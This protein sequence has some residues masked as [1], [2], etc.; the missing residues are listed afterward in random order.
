MP[1]ANDY[2][3]LF[4]AS[5][6]TGCRACQVA[7]KQWN[8]LPGEATENHGSYENP[9]ALS[10]DTWLRMKFTEGVV[11]GEVF[12]DFTRDSC[13]HCTSAACVES[14]PTGAVNYREGG[15]VTI[16]DN[17]CIGCR[18]CVQACPYEAIHFNEQKGVVEKCSMCYDRVSN[19]LEPACVK[20]CPTGALKSGTYAEMKKLAEERLAQL[21]AAGYKEANIYGLN[22][23]GGTHVIY[24]LLKHPSTY[25]LPVG[26]TT[27]KKK[28]ASGWLSAGIAAAVLGLA[29]VKW[30]SDRR[31]EVGGES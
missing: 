3:I 13:M 2:A 30:I 9:P 25:G 22:E 17:W 4:D 18:N 12:W 19:G 15:I 28:I 8:D 31:S 29:G 23:M 11:G 24:V 21:K 26:L 7:C 5:H 14:C 1:K 27:E 20:S 6:C 10:A 16:D